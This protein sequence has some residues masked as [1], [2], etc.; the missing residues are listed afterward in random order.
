MKTEFIPFPSDARQFFLRGDF[1]FELC[2]ADF[3]QSR[4]ARHCFN[5]AYLL[6]EPPGEWV[7]HY[8]QDLVKLYV[9]PRFFA[10]CVAVMRGARKQVALV[11]DGHLWMPAPKEGLFEELLRRTQGTD[12]SGKLCNPVVARMPAEV[13]DKWIFPNCI[14]LHDTTTQ[15]AAVVRYGIAKGYLAINRSS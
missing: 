2:F 15:S 10:Y 7:F 3:A 8:D 14:V 5:I 6:D 13:S 11:G 9:Q 12:Q 4:A 1:A